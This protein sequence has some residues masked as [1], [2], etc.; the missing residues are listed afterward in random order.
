MAAP[1]ILPANAP[2]RSG[3]TEPLSPE[4]LLE[5][6]EATVA[7]RAYSFEQLSELC[8]L[9]RVLGDRRHGVRSAREAA[10]AALQRIARVT[11][12]R[13]Q[14]EA[15]RQQVERQKCVL[16][17]QAA[18]VEAASSLAEALAGARIGAQQAVD[19][20]TAETQRVHERVGRA[21]VVLRQD[22]II[23]EDLRAMLARQRARVAADL[24]A[25][26][27]VAM[28]VDEADWTISGLRVSG[29]EAEEAAAA[30]GVVVRVVD[31]AARYL[32]APLRFPVVARASRSAVCVA[33]VDGGAPEWW[34]LFAV[35]VADRAR[36]LAAARLLAADIEQLLGLVGVALEPPAHRQAHGRAKQRS[37]RLLL[38]A[39]TQ[40]L[41][42]LESSSFAQ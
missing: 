37:V 2:T 16:Q 1:T 41:M 3:G 31:T 32:A 36:M 7:V 22:R 20:G 19:A 14:V 26:F 12:L 18:R 17:R 25:A 24:A 10:Q 38:P 13:Q 40:L 39:V 29:G 28:A 42:A 35:R 4:T 34:P 15:R 23:F 9:E 5:S 6:S 21:A 33:S 8:T 27:P 11:R 30:L